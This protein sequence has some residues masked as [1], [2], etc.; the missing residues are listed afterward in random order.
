MVQPLNWLQENVVNVVTMDA[1]DFHAITGII[2]GLTAVTITG[3][4]TE[5]GA[6]EEVAIVGTEIVHGAI[7]VETTEIQ[8]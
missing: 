7:A 4:V 5:I 1:L 3:V 8:G 6:T 2:D